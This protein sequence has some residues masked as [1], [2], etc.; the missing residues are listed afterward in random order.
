MAAK[1]LLKALAATTSSWLRPSCPLGQLARH[2]ETDARMYR[3]QA[4]IGAL[5]SQHLTFH[6]LA[7]CRGICT[8][9]CIPQHTWLLRAT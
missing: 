5:P 3:G 1:L 6:C 4:P 7:K 8:Q 9:H 2:K